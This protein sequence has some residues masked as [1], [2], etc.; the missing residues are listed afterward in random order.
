MGF[1]KVFQGFCKG[2]IGIFS[3]RGDGSRDPAGK[4][5]EFP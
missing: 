3:H 4:L 2:N 5:T 1:L